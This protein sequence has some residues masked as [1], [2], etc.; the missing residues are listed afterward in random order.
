MVNVPTKFLCLLKNS[1]KKKNTQANLTQRRYFSINVTALINSTGNIRSTKFNGKKNLSW[2]RYH[3][4]FFFFLT[5]LQQG[6]P[7][8]CAWK[9]MTMNWEKA[10]RGGRGGRDRVH[11]ATS[12]ASEEPP[13]TGWFSYDASLSRFL[14][15]SMD[16]LSRVSFYP[17][18]FNDSTS[19]HASH[20]DHPTL[21]PLSTRSRPILFRDHAREHPWNFH[22]NLALTV[23]SGSVS[24]SSWIINILYSSHVCF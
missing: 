18:L 20:V 19:Q 6:L 21:P 13:R 11:G 2:M 24:H 14:R 7:P 16:L 3:V 23:I 9:I 17:A 5:R 12:R 4:L 8:F 1:Q 10:S 22:R 15:G